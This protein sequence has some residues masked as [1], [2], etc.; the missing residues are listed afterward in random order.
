MSKYYLSK[1]KK[2]KRKLSFQKSRLRKILL[3]KK[4][5]QIIMN[6][7]YF[8]SIKEMLSSN[9]KDAVALAKIIVF[10]TKFEN[11]NYV[12]DLVENY[13]HHLMI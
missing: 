6:D 7:T 1:E 12:D 11:V 13:Y 8:Y 2:L 9:D 5:K 10:Q 3:S 4:K